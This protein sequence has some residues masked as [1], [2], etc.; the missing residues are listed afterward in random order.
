MSTKLVWITPEA[1]KLIAYCAR[2]SNP[3]NQD[4]PNYEKLLKYCMDHGHW[5]V[6]EMASAC[7]EIETTRAIA[8]QILR[9]KSFSFQEFS[10]RYSAATEIKIEE[11]RRQDLKNKQNSIDDLSQDTKDW[12][13]A[14]QQEVADRSLELYKTALEKGIAKECSRGLLPLN[15]KTTLYM[16]GTLRSWVHYFSLRCDVATQKEH[17]DLAVS[18]R[19]QLKEHLP[20]ITKSANW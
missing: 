1:E 12:F 4:N 18:M 17:R 9:H 16:S 19:E 7:F 10:Q 11:P 5:S 6:F 13:L 2:V 3:Q 8:P 14:A 20:I 15:T